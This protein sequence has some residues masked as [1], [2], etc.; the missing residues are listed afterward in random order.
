MT[1]RYKPILPIVVVAIAVS[2]LPL[3]VV[4]AEEDNDYDPSSSVTTNTR[5]HFVA[6]LLGYM[7]GFGSIMLY[8]PIAV[9]LLRQHHA[10]GLVISTW[11]LKLGSYLLNDVYYVRKGYDLSTYAEVLV[12]TIESIVVLVLVAIYQQQYRY[13]SFWTTFGLVCIGSLYGFTI[14]PEGLIATGQLLAVLINSLALCPQFWHNYTTKTKGDYSPVTAG[15]A[16]A[17]CAVRLFTTI[18]LNGSDPILM[19]SYFVALFL[20]GALLGQIVYYGVWVEGLT[21]RQVLLADV[22]ITTSMTS[23][24]VALPSYNGIEQ[25]EGSGC[26]YYNE[27]L[28]GDMSNSYNSFDDDD[29]VIATGNSNDD[30]DPLT[31]LQRRESFGNG[32]ISR[33]S[34]G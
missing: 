27:Q 3:N 30:N 14:A 15:L 6:K 28:Q 11:W 26:S 8:T 19:I 1:V 12:I 2:L 34:L 10:D 23:T 9:R 5:R 25:R 33:R 7:V 18:T 24:G 17:G 22:Q 20:N 16:V 32:T 31:I 29:M 4:L 21:L 13:G